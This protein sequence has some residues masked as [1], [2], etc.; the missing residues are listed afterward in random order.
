MISTLTVLVIFYAAE[1][2][3]VVKVK[4]GKK[5]IASHPLGLGQASFRG[6]VSD[7]F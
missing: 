2:F 7:F 5:T 3:W 1:L 4:N 6:F